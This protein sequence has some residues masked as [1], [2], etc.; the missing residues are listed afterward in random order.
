[1]NIIDFLY[2]E[3]QKVDFLSRKDRA[4]TLMKAVI[5]EINS[6]G[7][8]IKSD[9]QNILTDQ[10]ALSDLLTKADYRLELIIAKQFLQYYIDSGNLNLIPMPYPE[11]DV[12]K[13]RNNCIKALL[14]LILE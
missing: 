11:S 10:R 8:V 2:S 13:E 1:M 4:D 9:A 14:R 3:E 5:C 7:Y 12:E 6:I